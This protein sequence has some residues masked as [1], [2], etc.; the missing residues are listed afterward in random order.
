MLN[1][2]RTHIF[3]YD[4]SKL[5]FLIFFLLKPFYLLP[6]GSLQIGDFFLGLSFVFMIYRRKIK[7]EEIDKT[8]FA[9]FLCVII[10]NGIYG[11]I[12]THLGFMIS[13]IYYLFNLMV[14]MCFREFAH[15]GAFLK[16]VEVICKANLW[17]Q[18]AIYCLGLGE[19]MGGTYR[20]MGTYND[21]NQ[22]GFAII[23]TFFILYILNAKRLIVYFVISTF[24]LFQTSSSGMLLSI[25]VL[26]VFWVLTQVKSMNLSTL[27][28]PKMAVIGIG[29]VAICLLIVA[30]KNLNIIDMIGINWEH[31]RVEEKMNKGS[32]P[33]L[34][35]LKDRNMMIITEHPEFFLFGLGEG[36]TDR[37]FGYYGE[38][39]STVIS[40]CYY[41]GIFPFF[42]L[43]KWVIDN[44]KSIPLRVLPVY[45]AI[46]I[47]ALTLVNH[48]QP[49]FWM[50]II[51]ASFNISKM[52]Q[53]DEVQCNSTYLQCRKISE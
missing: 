8:F 38:L 27:R 32:N 19:Y 35:F 15:D 28:I 48:R 18:L 12:Y 39:H 51:L 53:K 44:I 17:I 25:T 31:F 3:E 5:C 20:Y 36:Y 14:I 24:L 13:S 21:P 43:V 1:K 41:Y 26:T 45:I 16:R 46:F 23:S 11:V 34:S 29:I 47:E 30:Y 52:G 22:L 10:I 9:F 6:S 49:S 7:L 42:I 40:L 4:L 50:I 2:L 33:I 37:Y